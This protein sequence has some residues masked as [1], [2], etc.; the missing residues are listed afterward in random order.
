MPTRCAVRSL[1][2]NHDLFG[3]IRMIFD[4]K[5][6]ALAPQR[7]KSDGSVSAADD[8]LL[9]LE[10]NGSNSSGLGRRW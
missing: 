2:G 4:H 6:V 8:D 5:R 1:F 7:A 9:D 10:A 3:R